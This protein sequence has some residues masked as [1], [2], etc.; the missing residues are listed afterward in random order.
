MIIE[1][2]EALEMSSSHLKGIFSEMFDQEQIEK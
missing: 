2:G 1:M